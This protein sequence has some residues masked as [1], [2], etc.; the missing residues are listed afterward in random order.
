MRA[1]ELALCVLC[2]LPGACTAG[3]DVPAPLVSGVTPDHAPPGAIVQLTG[4]HFCQLPEIREDVPCNPSGSVQ[5]DTTPA[6]AT[7]WTETS[8]MVEVPQGLTT[9]VQVRVLA[10]GHTSNAVTFTPT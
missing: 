7:S 6:T 1:S 2:A 5:F 10:G 3:D 8:I 9:P 4:D